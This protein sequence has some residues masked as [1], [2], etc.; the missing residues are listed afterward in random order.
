MCLSDPVSDFAFHCLTQI[1]INWAADL[2]FGVFVA[3]LTPWSFFLVDEL[4]AALCCVTN[5]RL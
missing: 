2:L 4:I 3:V 1:N 5:W